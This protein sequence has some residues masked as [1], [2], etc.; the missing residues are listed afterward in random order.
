[1]FESATPSLRTMACPVSV[2]P[3]W[4]PEEPLPD[5]LKSRIGGLLHASI[6]MSPPQPLRPVH[7]GAAVPPA[8]RK[9]MSD[10]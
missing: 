10:A 3:P 5:G 4:P 2:P 6:T 8:G 7:R 9:Q 1:M